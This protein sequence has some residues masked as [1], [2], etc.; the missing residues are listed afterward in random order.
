[1]LTRKVV[2]SALAAHYSQKFAGN[3]W[4]LYDVSKRAYVIQGEGLP[5][6]KNV[7]QLYPKG[8]SLLDYITPADAQ[9]IAA[10]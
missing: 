2:E 6:A 9:N 4:A 5:A 1:M 3:V 8:W 10:R 7:Q